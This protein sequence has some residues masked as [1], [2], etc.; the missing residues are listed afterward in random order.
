MTRVKICGITNLDDALRS[1]AFGADELG[2]N[3]YPK[4]P[5][6][7]T[8]RNAAA[9]ARG[10]PSHVV[11][12]G[13]FVN[14]TLGEIVRA[15]ENVSL[16]A[17]QLHG[18]ELPEFVAS[19]R[20]CINAFVIKAFR[21]SR[22]F[23]RDTIAGTGADAILLDAYSKNEYGGTGETFD[24]D[25]AAS[26]SKRVPMLYLA[27]GLSE[28]NVA[29]AIAAVNPYCVDA[30]SCLESKPGVKDEQKLRNFLQNAGKQQ[31]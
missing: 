11:K 28:H 23:D 29:D 5:R 25:I 30:C 7:V 13:V 24:W 18:D 10:L 21:V 3:F 17:V 19:V 15:A 20:E 14:E 26:V 8:P 6:Y 2:F 16:D 4:S 27:G 1:A 31:L 9:I 12:V 22:P